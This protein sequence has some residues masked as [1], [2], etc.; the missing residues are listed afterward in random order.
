MAGEV[1]PDEPDQPDQPAPE[2]VPQRLVVVAFLL[3][4]LCGVAPLAILGAGFA[5]AILI[6]RGRRGAG[7]G[8]IAVAVI[9]ATLGVLLR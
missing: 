9:C 2:E 3:A 4:L 8:V 7:A 1:V 5:G 6:Q